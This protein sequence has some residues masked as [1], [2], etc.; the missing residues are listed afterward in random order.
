MC[1]QEAPSSSPLTNLDLE[2]SSHASLV[3]AIMD[4]LV[5]LFFAL[6]LFSV[7]R[8]SHHPQNCPSLALACATPT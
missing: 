5:N 3:K 4:A 2:K 8:G 6:K 7:P 1:V